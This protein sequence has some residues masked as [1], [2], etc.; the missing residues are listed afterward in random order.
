MI[1]WIEKLPIETIALVEGNA[2]QAEKDIT[3]KEVHR[4]ETDIMKVRFLEWLTFGFA[5]TNQCVAA[6]PP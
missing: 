4:F 6:P 3:D 2:R 5:L 1:S